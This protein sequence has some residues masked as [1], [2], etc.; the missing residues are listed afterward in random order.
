MQNPVDKCLENKTGELINFW[1]KISISKIKLTSFLIHSIIGVCILGM[2]FK[3]YRRLVSS[4]LE[5]KIN[6]NKTT[7]EKENIKF[8]KLLQNIKEK[9]FEL[10]KL[11]SVDLHSTSDLYKFNFDLETLEQCIFDYLDSLNDLYFSQLPSSEKIDSKIEDICITAMKTT[12]ESQILRMKIL[13]LLDNS[14]QQLQNSKSIQQENCK[15]N[16]KNKK[17]CQLN[18]S[19]EDKILSNSIKFDLQTSEENQNSK[20]FYSKIDKLAEKIELKTKLL[21]QIISTDSSFIVKLNENPTQM[22][23]LIN[24]ISEY[25]LKVLDLCTEES[26][27]LSDLSHEHQDILVATQTTLFELIILLDNNNSKVPLVEN[28]F[29]K[30][31]AFSAFSLYLELQL[32]EFDIK[33]K[34]SDS[35]LAS[36]GQYKD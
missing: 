27:N 13:N 7:A 19:E 17:D 24:E 11:I 22:Q 36:E 16:I 20:N 23:N 33:S 5:N 28:I 2:L 26:K 14:S 25:S 8:E 30:N 35:L 12:Q 31:A 4:K 3:I 10:G 6:L 18:L 21:K 1:F 9:I 15:S 32:Q 29:I 34:L